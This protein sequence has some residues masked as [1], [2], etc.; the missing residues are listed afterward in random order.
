LVDRQVVGLNFGLAVGI[1]IGVYCSMSSASLGRF[2]DAYHVSH[3]L[4][5]LSFGLLR[6][7]VWDSERTAVLTE[8]DGW[9]FRRESQWAFLVA[10]ACAVKWWRAVTTDAAVPV[11]LLYCRLAVLWTCWHVDKRLC[12]WYTILFVGTLH[13]HDSDQ[14][15]NPSAPHRTALARLY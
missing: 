8:L 7:Y 4:A 13:D 1:G 9:G 14:R 3:G 11:C 10:G 6:V 12:A 15:P 2:F 5:L